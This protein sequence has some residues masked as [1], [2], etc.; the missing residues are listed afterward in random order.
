MGVLV[1]ADF[2]AAP[3]SSGISTCT[4]F[5]RGKMERFSANICT[6][7]HCIALYTATKWRRAATLLRTTHTFTRSTFMAQQQTVVVAAAIAIAAAVVTDC[8]PRCCS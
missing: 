8:P 7:V 2:N 1:G 5:T 4:Y 6:Y 3:S